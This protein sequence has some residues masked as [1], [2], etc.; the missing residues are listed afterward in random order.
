MSIVRVGAQAKIF[1]LKNEIGTYI[2]SLFRMLER[3]SQYKNICDIFLD[4]VSVEG[5][6]KDKCDK[7]MDMFKDMHSIVT[8]AQQACVTA[9]FFYNL[10]ISTHTDIFNK[11]KQRIIFGDAAAAPV[12]HINL[13]ESK[14][15]NDFQTCKKWLD[16]EVRAFV[17]MCMGYRNSLTNDSE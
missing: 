3:D 13:P 1:K 16:G 9:A 2:A 17:K 11:K 15:D 8:T 7:V 12:V 5:S 10:T 6:T 14:R 4:L